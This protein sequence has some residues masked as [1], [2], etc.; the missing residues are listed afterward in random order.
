MARR[1]IW[2]GAISFG[3]V[4]IPVKL[5]TATDSNDINFVN[6]HSTCHTRIRQPRYCPYHEQVVESSE[7]VRAYEY[8][9]EQYIVMEDSDFENVPVP[10]KHTIEITQFVD[11][12]SIDPIYFERSYALE[13]QEIGVKPFYLLKQALESTQRVAIAKLSLRQKEHLCCLRPYEDGIML[14]T[15]HYPSEIRGVAELTLPEGEISITKQ[16]MQMAKTLIDQLTDEFDATRYTD[17]YREALEAIIQ[18][19]LGTGETVAEPAPAPQG[20]VGDLMEALRASI[21]STK[22]ERAGRAAQM[23][24]TEESKPK[25]TRRTRAKKGA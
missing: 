20:K 16:E 5:Y 15:M 24:E 8:G 14:A 13:P 4:V 7:I 23:E 9:K 19:K 18:N 3:M 17:Q 1:S 12:T 10:S 22:S 21:E 25:R 6:L 2:N 11:L